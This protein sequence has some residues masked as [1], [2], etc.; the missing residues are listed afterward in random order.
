LS[1]F[2]DSVNRFMAT[3][4]KRIKRGNAMTTL[5]QIN[6]SLF[7]AGGQSTQ[8]ADAFVENW[9][10]SHAE[11]EFVVRDLAGPCASPQCDR[12]TAMTPASNVAGSTRNRFIRCADRRDQA[13]TSGFMICCPTSAFPRHYKP[14]DHLARAGITFKHTP[15]ASGLRR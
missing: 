7:S 6:T 12:L 14:T 15:Q 5:L 13:E 8:L 2:I 10:N 9:R 1:F 11:A 3:P 4:A